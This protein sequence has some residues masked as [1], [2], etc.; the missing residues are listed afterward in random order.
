MSAGDLDLIVKGAGSV[1][2]PTCRWTTGVFALRCS[3]QITAA[4]AATPITSPIAPAHLM[5]VTP[6]TRAARIP[7]P[8]IEAAKAVRTPKAK[9]AATPNAGM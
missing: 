1:I 6:R 7:K 8:G 5:A 4:A 2:E 9:A 3:S